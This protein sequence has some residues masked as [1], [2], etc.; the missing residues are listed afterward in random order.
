[1]IPVDTFCTDVHVLVGQATLGLTAKQISTNAPALRVAMDFVKTISDITLVVVILDMKVIIVNMILTSVITGHAT[2]LVS[3][4]I[5]SGMPLAR[6]SLD[7]TGIIAKMTS[8]SAQ[9][10]HVKIKERVLT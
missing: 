3:V 2:T 5:W 9:A 10:I 8:M 1:V 6:V 7:M 4:M